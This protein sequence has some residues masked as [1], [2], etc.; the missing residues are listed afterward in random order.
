M[1]DINSQ[2]I[3]NT[4][5]TVG[6]TPSPEQIVAFRQAVADKLATITNNSRT[7]TQD[8][9]GSLV[10]VGVRTYQKWE[11]GTRTMSR[12]TWELFVLKSVAYMNGVLSSYFNKQPVTAGSVRKV[13]KR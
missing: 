8:R 12:A 5:Q 6:I 7:F 9:A 2:V 3:E 4:M 13:A 10:Y 11:Y 1:K